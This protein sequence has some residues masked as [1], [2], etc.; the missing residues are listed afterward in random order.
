MN[1][2]IVR[3]AES[4]L[5]NQGISHFKDDKIHLIEFEV[6]DFHQNTSYL[7]FK[8]KS[9]ILSKHTSCL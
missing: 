8:I 3:H 2:F 7:S 4:E 1:I 5:I 6:R 9:T